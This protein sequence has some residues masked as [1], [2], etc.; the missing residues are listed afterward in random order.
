MEAAPAKVLVVDDERGMREVL[1]AVLGGAGHS[2]VEA[3]SGEEAVRLIGSD[4]FD[5]V[6]TDLKMAGPIGGMDV[7]KAVKDISPNTVVIVLTA[8]ATLEVGVEAVK[9]GAYDVLTKPFNNDHVELTV[10]KAL[11]AKRLTAENLLLKRELKGL[12]SFENFIGASESMLKVFTLIHRV[13]DTNSTVLIC[14]ESGTGKELVARAIHDN[15]PRRDRSFVTVNCG[16][17][18]EPLLESELFGHM[19]GS[20]TGAVA[21]K[22][23]LFEVADGGTVFLDEIADAP[24]GIQVKLL[25]VLQEREFRQIGGTRNIKVDVRIIAATNKD[26]AKVV[27]QG[28]FRE[29]LYY[30]LDVIPIILPPLRSRPEDIPLL[31]HHFLAVFCRKANK[32]VLKVAPAAMRVLKQYE[33]RGNVRELENVME[34]VVALAP[35]PEITLND[36][37]QWLRGSSSGGL[38]IPADLPLE[39]LDLE[40]LI[41]GIER[42]LLVKA[43]ERSGGVKKEAARLLKLNARSFRYRVDKYGIKTGDESN[44]GS[45]ESE[46]SD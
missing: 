31:V 34:R 24:P 19:R 15:S 46:E 6:I 10:H 23:G 13:A 38:G 1:N 4:I 9:L 44:E 7:L 3:K 41:N 8:Y 26:L 28:L 18:P 5:L 12:A 29:D 35:G 11:D 37:A 2:V 22:E 36:L 17:L 39:G 16:A 25:R 43:L 32:P 40:G 45:D 42:D 30:R 14:G 33:W 20:F 21:N 27:A